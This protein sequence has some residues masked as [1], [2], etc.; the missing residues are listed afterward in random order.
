MLNFN[1]CLLFSVACNIAIKKLHQ[2]FSLKNIIY[3]YIRAKKV[4]GLKF[5][6]NGDYW[7]SNQCDD[8]ILSQ[9]Q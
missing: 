6:C 9:S 8:N 2:K 4:R 3:A 7:E 5:A 1:F